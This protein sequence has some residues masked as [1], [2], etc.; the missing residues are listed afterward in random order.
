MN[1][2]LFYDIFFYLVQNINRVIKRNSKI[3]INIKEKH[4]YKLFI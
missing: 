4:N 1:L 2:I 3:L